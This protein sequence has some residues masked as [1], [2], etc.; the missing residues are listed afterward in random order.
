MYELELFF[1]N[2]ELPN[3]IVLNQSTI[4]KDV[5]KFIK[6]HFEVLKNNSGNK[7][8][9]PYWNRLVQVKKILETK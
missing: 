6:S 5:P 3:E 4:I 9:M 8:Y 2:T 1:N 7:A